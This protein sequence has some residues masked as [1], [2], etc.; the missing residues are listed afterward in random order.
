MPTSTIDRRAGRT[1]SSTRVSARSITSTGIVPP[2]RSSA[3]PTWDPA[4]AS[5]AAPMLSLI[6]CRDEKNVAGPP[7]RTTS[8]TLTSSATAEPAISRR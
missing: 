1:V 6:A 5:P 7:S 8:A 2:P 4:S 3:D